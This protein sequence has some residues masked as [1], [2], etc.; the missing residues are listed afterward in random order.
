MKGVIFTHLQ[1][2]IESEQGFQV[3]DAI[4]ERCD[5]ASGGVF[6]ATERYP[7]EELFAIVTELS[8]VTDTAINDLL[9]VF[10]EYLFVNLH[11]SMPPE[12]FAPLTLWDLLKG[13]DSIIHMEVKKLD[14]KAQPP[15]LTVVRSSD[16][17][18]VLEYRSAKKLCHLAMGMLKSAAAMFD[19]DVTLAMPL[20]I[21]DG[22][23]HCE[24]VITRHV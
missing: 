3:W 16:K 15:S 14:K 13:L 5:L 7:D 9:G 22:H 4:L 23:D 12:V 18:M 19:E 2:M 8:T 20:C 21:H 11:K 17:E 6:V 1:E 24:L 10:G